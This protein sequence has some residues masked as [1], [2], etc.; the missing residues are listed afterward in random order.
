M[1]TPA[2]RQEFSFV[3]SMN[4]QRRQ[5]GITEVVAAVRAAGSAKSFPALDEDGKPSCLVCHVG[6]GHGLR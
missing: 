1:L 2:R 6:C 4:L 5:H 3:V